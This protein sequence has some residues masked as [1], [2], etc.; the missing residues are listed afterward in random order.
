MKGNIFSMER[1]RD[2]HRKITVDWTEFKELLEQKFSMLAPFCGLPECEERIKKD[3][4]N[5]EN[6]DLG[7]PGMG[8]KTLCIPL[9]Q[10][11]A[12]ITFLLVSF[13]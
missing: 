8:A 13:H 6:I 2:E 11:C 9:K 5:E 12:F 10:V 4:S 7:A 3:S 1:I